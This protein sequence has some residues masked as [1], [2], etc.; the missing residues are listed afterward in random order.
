MDKYGT[1]TELVEKLQK[2]GNALSTARKFMQLGRSIDFIQ[3]AQHSLHLTDAVLRW[4]IT[5]SK[6]NQSVALLFDHILW[7]GR[8]G[9]ATVDK[10]KW[11]ILSAQFWMCTLILNLTRDIYEIYLV[12]HNE[13]KQRLSLASR[14]H[15]K[16]GFSY[17]KDITKF[18]PT[19]IQLLS[20]SISKNKPIFLDL[21][22]NLFDSVLALENLG[23]IKISPGMQGLAGTI[24]SVIGILSVWNP[25]LKLIPS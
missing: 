18:P 20:I 2:L 14:S 8:I 6:L 16:N 5:L 17:H 19:N 24:S 1:D 10:D 15:Y 9:L 11:N 22:K 23:H 25:R 3:S 13:L 12:V 4:T 7:A 21:V